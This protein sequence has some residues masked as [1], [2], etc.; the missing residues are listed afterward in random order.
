MG[1]H[2][3]WILW[4]QV[5]ANS[6]LGVVDG[7]PKTRSVYDGQLQL[8][9]LFLNVHSVLSDVHCLINSLLRFRKK[10]QTK[11]IGTVIYQ[12]SIGSSVGTVIAMTHPLRWAISCLYANQWGTGCSPGWIYRGQTHLKQTHIY[13]Q[14][15]DKILIDNVMAEGLTFTSFYYDKKSINVNEALLQVTSQEVVSTKEIS[16][17]TKLNLFYLVHHLWKCS[18][19]LVSYQPFCW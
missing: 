19:Y 11:K 14:E 8:H 5:I 10:N 18:V 13:T 2:G 9:T 17:K 4:F 16:D 12:D 6:P 3:Y 7:I 15:E 1:L